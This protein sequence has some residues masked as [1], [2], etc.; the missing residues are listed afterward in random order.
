[1]HF[2][3]SHAYLILCHQ[4]PRHL[5]LWAKRH[6]DS[7]F[8]VHYDA[9]SDLAELDFLRDLENVI[10]L[11]NRVAIHWGGFSMVRAT[12]SLF[13]AALS[14][15]ENR[16]FH[17]MSGCCVPLKSPNELSNAFNTLPE[18]ALLLESQSTPRL[19]YRTR[20]NA[21]HADTNWQRHFLGKIY[22]KCLQVADQL[23]ISNERCLS[24][25]QWFSG[26][27]LAIQALLNEK[28]LDKAVLRFEKKL[29]PDEHFFQYL[30]SRLPE[31]I[32]LIN[33]N[34]RFIRFQAGKNHP[35]EL[36]IDILLRAKKDGF[37]FARKVNEATLMRF[38]EQEKEV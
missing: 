17:L 6:P 8:Y 1:M 25:S 14:H 33:N 38:L 18:N 13:Q 10:I 27:R 29:C 34:Q 9:K 24:G 15:S 35:D 19:R 4:A 31:N 12:L 36:N 20:F 21:L 3:M 5:S 28:A 11:P 37:W 26:T 23:W 16:F 22:T 7:R 32:T 2:S 30:A